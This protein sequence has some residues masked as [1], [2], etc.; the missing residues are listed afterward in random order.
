MGCA[1]TR[2]GRRKGNIRYPQQRMWSG[3]APRCLFN[4][5]VPWRRMNDPACTPS[6]V[7][8][9]Q[10]EHAAHTGAGGHRRHSSF[11]LYKLFST[12][13]AGQ[14]LKQSSHSDHL[15]S[16]AAAGQRNSR[17]V[18][19]VVPGARARATWT[20]WRPGAGQ[21]HWLIISHIGHAAGINIVTPSHVSRLTRQLG[22]HT[23]WPG[24][25]PQGHVCAVAVLLY[26]YSIQCILCRD[27]Y[28]LIT[29]LQQQYQ[30]AGCHRTCTG[31]GSGTEYNIQHTQ[32]MSTHWQPQPQCR[33]LTGSKDFTCLNTRDL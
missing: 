26:S 30:C 1:V 3:G 24:R 32:A 25:G 12:L 10:Q 20:R 29:H 5:P 4:H 2:A 33:G 28:I 19:K 21:G 31:L 17:S 27:M 11:T 22:G 8:S 6:F 16:A 7:P 18:I 15:A 23:A 9:S 13:G 14:L